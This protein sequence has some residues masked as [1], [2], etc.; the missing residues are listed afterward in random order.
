MS[1]GVSL[2]P[3]D[4]VVSHALDGKNA[5]IKQA[6]AI[7]EY[8]NGVPAALIA[9][10]NAPTD[11]SKERTE[12]Y[13]MGKV[14]LKPNADGTQFLPATPGAVAQPSKNSSGIKFLKALI[15]AGFPAAR[16]GND[17][18]VIDGTTVFLRAQ[19]R[20][21]TGNAEIDT[22]NADKP[23]V[24]PEKVITLPEEG[25]AAK[26]SPASPKKPA[27]AKPAPAVAATPSGEADAPAADGDFDA[28]AEAVKIVSDVLA[29]ADNNTVA[30]NQ[31]GGKVFGALAK[32]KPTLSGEARKAILGAINRPG[33]YE[34]EGRPWFVDADAKALVGPPAE[35]AEA[36]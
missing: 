16:I 24:L 14:A 27:V 9:V 11:G 6:R 36:A 5:V 2:N 31:I 30:R 12:L 25:T 7:G 20:E 32:V 29:K 3:N 21:K 33:F 13:S 4:A 1:Q 18:S 23:F 22:K 17:L 34:W 15:S 35:E 19:S 10:L 26:K 8:P 28:E